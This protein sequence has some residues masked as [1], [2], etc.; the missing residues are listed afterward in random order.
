MYLISFVNRILGSI[1][2]YLAML[3]KQNYFIGQYTYYNLVELV[4]TQFSGINN[5][6]YIVSLICNQINTFN[7]N[8][9]Y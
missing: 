5:T 9:F 2:L 1:I 7:N 8:F 3:N 6:R 4:M